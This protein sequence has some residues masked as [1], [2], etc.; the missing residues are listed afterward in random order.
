[1]PNHLLFIKVFTN[2]VFR[3]KN[4]NICTHF[5]KKNKSEPTF[6]KRHFLNPI[7]AYKKCFIKLNL[8]FTL[9]FRS[10]ATPKPSTFAPVPNST[11]LDAVPQATP[12]NRNRVVHKK[13]RTFPLCFDD[14]DP[15]SVH[16][17]AALSETLVP[18]RLDMVRKQNVENFKGEFN[19]G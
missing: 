12:I 14:S 2:F 19:A 11:H 17:N 15:A 13:V 3:I 7:F 10:K 5:S 18:I 9:F 4:K 16:E 1:M 8:F 6:F